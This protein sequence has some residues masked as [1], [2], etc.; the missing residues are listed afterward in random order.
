MS[1][2]YLTAC[3]LNH[4]TGVTTESIPELE[5]NTVKTGQLLEIWTHLSFQNDSLLSIL[6]ETFLAIH[7]HYREQNHSIY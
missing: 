3:T 2:T 4:K 6:S 5:K 7:K 1:T